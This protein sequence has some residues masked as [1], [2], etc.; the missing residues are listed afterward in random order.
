MHP[1]LAGSGPEPIFTTSNWLRPSKEGQHL[2]RAN[3]TTRCCLSKPDY[4][5][6]FYAD[7]RNVSKLSRAADFK[8][9]TNKSTRI[10][11]HKCDRVQ[12]LP[13]SP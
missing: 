2:A 6:S 7:K 4:S 5:T 8:L 3:R 13:A 1:L 11:E 9:N 10:A 12:Q